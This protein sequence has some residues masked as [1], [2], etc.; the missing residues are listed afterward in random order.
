MDNGQLIWEGLLYGLTLTALM[1]PI[2]VALTQTGIEKGVRAGL[3]VG[4]GIWISDIII[5]AVMISLLKTLNPED[6]EGDFKK[7][8][9]LIGGLILIVFGLGTALKKASFPNNKKAFTAKSISGYWLKGFLVNTINPFTFIF[10]TTLI[11]AYVV[12]KDL[13]TFQINLFFGTIIATIM[14]TDTLKV[15]GAKAIRNK[16]SKE[17]M[18]LISKIAGIALIVFGIALIYR[19]WI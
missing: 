11:T 13:N 8:F 17:D 2:F 1:G 15:L 18:M 3:L 19:S 10:W 9:G 16:L 12:V 5:I 14:V 6:L 4:L 7:Y